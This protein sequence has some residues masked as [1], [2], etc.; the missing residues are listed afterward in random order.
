MP[1]K[2]SRYAVFA[3][4][5]SVQVLFGLNYVITKLVIGHFPPLVWASFRLVIS[6]GIL[7]WIGLMSEGSIP[8]KKFKDYYRPLLLFALLGACLNQ[9]SFLVGLKYT[10]PANSAILNT[11]IPIFTL[12]IV[13]MRGQESLT[14]KRVIGFASALA[15]VLV[16]RKI[17]DFRLSNETFVGDL[18]TVVNCICY[19]IYLSIS[20]PFWEKNN[21]LWATAWMFLFG[22]VGLTGLAVP[23]WI[24]FE[25]PVFTPLLFGC[26][27]FAIFGGTLLAYFLNNWAL[28]FS[29]SSN[30][31]LWVYV[32][33][34]IAAGLSWVW[35]GIP[36]NLRT[37]ASSLLIFVGMVLALNHGS[38]SSR[39]KR[40]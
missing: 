13:V 21:R 37:V 38:K 12:M 39:H 17:E 24:G 27:I 6:A 25:W 29:P 20:K 8:R 35:L 28:A 11:L 23:D 18:L 22:S 34:V 31:A 16:I 26:V 30:V 3:A 9:A 1:S 33:P 5:L 4:L 32:Q 14:V 7:F 15:G 36:V 2:P 10:T 19:A 40:A